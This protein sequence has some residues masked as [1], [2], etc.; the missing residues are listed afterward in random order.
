LE[1]SQALELALPFVFTAGEGGAL[2]RQ[3]K[4]TL[5]DLPSAHRLML[6]VPASDV[7]LLAVKL[8]APLSPSRLKSALPNLLEEQ[9]LAAVE[10]CH[11]AAGPYQAESGSLPVAVIHRSW[12]K[13]I[14]E[15]IARQNFA[16][17]Y[18]VPGQFM[19]APGSLQVTTPMALEG[20]WQV[21]S[22]R[23]RDF[24]GAGYAVASAQNAW[25]PPPAN[26][27]PLPAAVDFAAAVSGFK[28]PFID[29]CQFE[30]ARGRSLAS[31]LGPWKNAL[32]MLVIVL[33]AQVLFVNLNWGILAWQKH[34]LGSEMQSLMKQTVPSAPANADPLS[35]V[36]R[37]LEKQRLQAGGAM[38]GE[39][40]G[41]AAHL[42]LLMKS[43]PGDAITHVEYD[44]QSLLVKF[45]AGYPAAPLVRKAAGIPGVSLKDM[46]QGLWK[47]TWEG[48]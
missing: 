7:L 21:V 36:S 38:P 48:K 2:L 47:F 6:V 8:P 25:L 4:S 5:A 29:L 23:E 24:G 39:F 27:L 16:E 3:G 10:D 28:A 13:Q 1:A 14:L 20:S 37:A 33:L 40:P 41:L 11:F 31:A 34:R 26:Q 17:I 22:W 42:S 35:T 32:G 9:L 44:H 45:K 15:A 19:Q 43:E 12:L 46:G 18:V 30:F